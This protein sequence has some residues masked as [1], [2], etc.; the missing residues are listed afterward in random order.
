MENGDLRAVVRYF[1]PLHYPNCTYHMR[2]H[3]DGRDPSLPPALH[4]STLHCFEE[5]EGGRSGYSG[6]RNAELGQVAPQPA[7][8]C[9]RVYLMFTHRQTQLPSLLLLLRYRNLTEPVLLFLLLWAVAFNTQS[10]VQFVIVNTGIG[11]QGQTHR[12]HRRTTQPSNNLLEHPR[13]DENEIIAGVLFCCHC[14]DGG[15][16]RRGRISHLCLMDRLSCN[17]A[18]P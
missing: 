6:V 14:M 18:A 3:A 16:G 11:P 4:V 13:G 15:E 5:K 7:C 2:L 8:T 12:C 10:L 17:E 1:L 9:S